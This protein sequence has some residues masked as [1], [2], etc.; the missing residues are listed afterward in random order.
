M[1]KSKAAKRRVSLKGMDSQY[2]VR[3]A[4]RV[5]KAADTA[6][7]PKSVIKET[8]PNVDA[9]K[10]QFS[11][12]KTVFASGP[13][14]KPVKAEPK[15]MFHQTRV[16]L[17]YRIGVGDDLSAKLHSFSVQYEIPAK[18]VLKSA[19]IRA[20]KA[21]KPILDAPQKPIIPAIQEGGVVVV[22]S[23]STTGKCAENVIANFDPLNLGLAPAAIRPIVV[24]LIQK[25]LR[26]IVDAAN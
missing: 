22:V 5:E 8:N 23:T 26:A 19:R 13:N 9:S 24:D 7:A 1:E 16:R 21:L 4:L 2:A 6:P 18:D 3:D 11:P 12:R 15:D 10:V 14:I 17:N 25:E 20:L